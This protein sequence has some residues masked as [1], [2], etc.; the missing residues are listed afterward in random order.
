MYAWLS[1]TNTN[2]GVDNA[3]NDPRCDGY[4][5][6]NDRRPPRIVDKLDQRAWTPLTEE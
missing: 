4:Y 5:I 2:Y 3:I 1:A 6:P